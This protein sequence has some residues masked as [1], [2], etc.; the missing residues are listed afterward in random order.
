M[1]SFNAAAL[2]MRTALRLVVALFTLS[3]T[4]AAQLASAQTCPV[5]AI[6]YGQTISG[7]LATTDCYEEISGVRFYLDQYNFTGTAGQRIAITNSSSA[8]NA[9]LTLIHPNNTTVYD[10]NG[11][12][13]TNSRIPASSGFYTLPQT[14][15]Y[16]IWAGTSESPLRAGAYTLSLTSAAA[17]GPPSDCTVA[18]NP[19]SSATLPLPAGTSVTMSAA[20][21]QGTA[22]ITFTWDNGA[23]SGASRTV[24]PSQTTT[25]SIVASNASGSSAPFTITVHVAAAA[26]IVPTIEFYNIHLAHYFITAVQAEA[27]AIDNGSAGA[28]WVR[29]GFSYDVYEK[30]TTSAGVAT[31]P[32]CRFYGTPGVGPNSHFYTADAQECEQ[33]KKDPGWTYEGIAYHIQMP[34]NGA[35]PSGTQPIYRTY[36]NR[37]AQNDSNH[38]F[39]TN[40]Q[41]Y[42]QLADKN[43]V[44]EGIVMCTK[45]VRSPTP[46]TGGT[47]KDSSGSGAQMSIGNGELPPYVNAT[48][49][50]TG[51]ARQGQLPSGM[52]DPGAGES[53]V[54]AAPTGGFDFNLTGDSGFTTTTPGAVTVSV[55][56]NASA[57]P[58]ADA[59]N[60]A[61]TFVRIHD[62]NDGTQVDVAGE[63]TVTGTSGIV[64]VSTQGL[65][66][67]FI[68][69]V[70]HSPGVESL[71]SDEVI[72]GEAP[73]DVP[74]KSATA[75]TWPG[76]GYCL[77]GNVR[78]PG[79]IAAARTGL[80]LSRDPTVTEIK[81]FLK[82]R[83]SAAAVA[84]QAMM[85]NDNLAPPN[86]AMTNRH[87]GGGKNRYFIHIVDG[88][89]PH[90]S[91]EDPGAG[92]NDLTGVAY[93]RLYITT[94]YLN[95]PTSDP[96]G[97]TAS[98]V[99]HEMF[100][101]VQNSY[102][103]LGSTSR[104]YREGAATVYGKS[105]DFNGQ[106]TV[107]PHQILMLSSELLAPSGTNRY[108]SE[109]F[110]AYI[111]R[112]YNLGKLEFMSGLFA[113]MRA[114][115]GNN[116]YNP[117]R[118]SM[119]GALDTFLKAK[120][121]QSLNAV[122]LDFLNQRAM[123]HNTASRFG[124]PGEVTSGLAENL[125]AAS[126]IGRRAIDVGTCSSQKVTI[127]ANNLPPFA[128][129]AIILT[130]TGSLPSGNTSGVTLSVKVIVGNSSVGD[131]WNG[132]TR[133]QGNVDS[134]EETN[135]FTGFGRSASDRA[136]ILVANL[137]PTSNRS[138][139][140]EIS[141]GGV[142]IDSLSPNRGKT[143]DVVTINGSGFG[144]ANAQR[145]VTFNGVSS[146]SVTY[147]SD[148]Q[149]RATVPA[150]ASSGN[151][152]VTVNGEIS[153]GVNF[154]IVAVCSAQQNAGGDTPDTRTIELG[155]TGGTFNFTYNTYSQQDRII[156]R[157]QNNVLF[158]TGCVGTS[159]TRSLSYNGTATS[160]VVQV[161]PNC[162]G[163][164]GTAWDYTVSCPT[165]VIGAVGP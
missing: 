29:T 105:F 53:N 61:R 139:T 56:F 60:P 34:A 22:P 144:T 123:S 71:A 9:D 164:T 75:T 150:N 33:V 146:T 76:Q 156:V 165:T 32:V 97:S 59:T 159:A 63:N 40:A 115:L 52:T 12:G 66:Q 163:G 37:A 79:L 93:G 94:N 152:I 23:F 62:P 98:A 51:P 65:P 95:V 147:V 4:G 157:Y 36:N 86:L 13:G 74:L 43:W 101:A 54:T 161:I 153:N 160:I 114:S 85:Q 149:L 38:R 140:L 5:T 106:I 122:Y 6:A 121:G 141:C 41:T 57:I 25:Y 99:A 8:F 155:R 111:G 16:R 100:H 136:E 126:A 138:F 45:S 142:K 116:N 20:C 17:A 10:D 134:L 109:D 119:Y 81:R 104:S 72:P 42:Q 108:G 70:I 96:T 151:V 143:G 107:R 117:D 127:S 103:I 24:T 137:D 133:W 67:Q 82:D 128:S 84:A 73:V 89:Q 80:G 1:P 77:I 78:A 154:D 15:S 148:T 87:C 102:R 64:T 118:A 162:A 131:K 46:V 58:A 130:P 90:F 27:T 145:R 44:Q 125:F 110:W 47:F 124:R 68:A 158:D 69:S 91:G 55:P 18:A 14:G 19:Q 31:V 120:F 113:Q 112:A 26:S 7:T 92:I 39:I 2:T 132:W 21:G 83:V 135:R 50:Q 3:L 49:P 30:P 129:P 11:G 48:Q 88:T 28:G 35:C